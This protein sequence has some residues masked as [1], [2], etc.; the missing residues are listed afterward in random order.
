[1]NRVLEQIIRAFD[2]AATFLLAGAVV[3][4]GYI[5]YY[6]SYDSFLLIL[7]LVLGGVLSSAVCAAFHELGHVLFGLLCGF[8]FNSMRIGFVSISRSEGKIRCTAKRLPGPLAGATQMLPT[9][10][11]NLYEKFLVTVCGGPAFSLLFLAGC[12]VA[13]VFYRSL[14]FSVYTLICTAMPYAF[15]ILFYNVLPFKDD[16]L[17]TDGA[18]IRGLIKRE[19]SYL[20]AVNVLAIEGYMYQ[21]ATPSE[22]DKSLYFGLP[23]LPEDD[24]NFIILTNYRLMYFLDAGDVKEAI[25]ASDRLE[26]LLE[27]VPDL[28]GKEIGADILYVT[29]ALKHDAEK[30]R[31]M[32]PPLRQFLLGENTLR[33][34]RISAAY[35]LYVN[36]DKRKALFELNAAEQ[37][38]ETCPILGEG[39]F[40]RK[41]LGSIRE[42][43]VTEHYTE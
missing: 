24:L 40:E 35:E 9:G 5:N 28:F 10:R 43:I 42:N 4:V 39:K 13:M 20:T 38:T 7:S 29:C 33:T 31:A 27:Y 18:M 16:N 11:E 26:S 19:P 30:A 2:Y 21:G 34:H 32:Y 12:I 6:A 1:M 17:D 41:L 22:I 14:H 37:K 8:R 36:G 15:H 25:R 23:Q 3:W